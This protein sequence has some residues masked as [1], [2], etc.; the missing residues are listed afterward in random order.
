VVSINCTANYIPVITE[1]TERIQQ[2]EIVTP[3]TAELMHIKVKYFITF[4]L[5][6][7]ALA[8][9]TVSAELRAILRN[10]ICKTVQF[11]YPFLNS[12]HDGQFCTKFCAHR[13]A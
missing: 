12:A 2:L 4:T 7:F 13:I 11:L 5:K 1:I 9:A 10:I 6:C 3:V 8:V